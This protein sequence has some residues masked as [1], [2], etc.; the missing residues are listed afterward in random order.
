MD[1][2]YRLPKKDILYL[3]SDKRQVIIATAT[4]TYRVY[5]KLDDLEMDLSDPTF[6]R[7]HKRYLI[8]SRHVTYVGSD[9]LTVA[10]R[11]F[12]FSRSHKKEAILTLA[13]RM[14]QE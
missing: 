1:G 6:I 9:S 11:E 7:I 13:K 2:T 8:N 3:E 10:G 14:V 4:A 5:A 12:P